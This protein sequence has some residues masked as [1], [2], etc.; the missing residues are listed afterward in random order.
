M[1]KRQPLTISAAEQVSVKDDLNTWKKWF[2]G[3]KH[4]YMVKRLP[5]QK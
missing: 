3:I 4:F 5:P 2:N 1:T